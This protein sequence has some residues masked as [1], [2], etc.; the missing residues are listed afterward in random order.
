MTRPV[1][2]GQVNFYLLIN[3]LVPYQSFTCM[4]VQRALSF[5][6]RGIQIIKRALSFGQRGIQIIETNEV[7]ASREVTVMN[8]FNLSLMH[9]STF[10]KYLHCFLQETASVY[11]KYQ[12]KK[13]ASVYLKYQIKKDSSIQVSNLSNYVCVTVQ[14]GFHYY[15]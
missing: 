13:T 11:L 1:Y 2:S 12:I 4:D 14:L 6:Q 9:K 7:I 3:K 8:C 5:G 15:F 10:I